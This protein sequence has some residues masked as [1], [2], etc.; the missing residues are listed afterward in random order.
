MKRFVIPFVLALVAAPFAHASDDDTIRI[1][2]ASGCSDRP[3]NSSTF[4]VE[5]EDPVAAQRTA[6]LIEMAKKD[7]RA[8]WD[9]GL[10]YFRG[11]GVRKD[12]YQALQWMRDAGERGHVEAQLAVGRFYL[13]GL[14]EMGSDPAEAETWLSMAA[15]KGNKEAKKLLAQARSAK[16]DEQELYRLRETYRKSWYGYWYSGYTYYG[17]WGPRGW[18]YR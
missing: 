5:A 7:P 10:R 13:M 14:E 12:S 3:K 17:T 1:C 9:L 2:D 4:Q 6:A 18:Y 16:N 8:A 15:G 11:D